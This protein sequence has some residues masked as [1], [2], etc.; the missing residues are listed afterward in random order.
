M[1]IRPP[2][3]TGS[4]VFDDRHGVARWAMPSANRHIDKP[5]LGR[6][7]KF[8]ERAMKVRG[9]LKLCDYASHILRR[10]P[11][12]RRSRPV[13]EDIGG[14][15]R[16]QVGVCHSGP[17]VG[18]RRDGC[19][20]M[21]LRRHHLPLVGQHDST[22]KKALQLPVERCCSHTLSVSQWEAACPRHSESVSPIKS[23][24][25]RA[26][27]QAPEGPPDGDEPVRQRG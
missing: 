19:G 11:R 12:H 4:N 8:G 24:S 7:A 20:Q 18:S 6:L 13:R 22:V 3:S 14:E 2:C 1:A 23:F 27:A 15:Q 10:Q 21:R 26:R 25:G 5:A 16:A 17:L 9:P